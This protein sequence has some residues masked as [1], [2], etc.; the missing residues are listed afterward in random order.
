MQQRSHGVAR[1]PGRAVGLIRIRPGWP[2]D[3]NVR[4]R[5]II[6]KLLEKQSPNDG[7]GLTAAFADVLDVRDLTF[8]VLLI[9]FFQW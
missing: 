6:H 5:T 8:D 7:P 4:P 2:G 3:I 9:F 1:G